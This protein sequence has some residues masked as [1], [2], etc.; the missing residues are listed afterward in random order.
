[1]KYEWKKADKSIYLPKN[2]PEI[3]ELPH[4]KYFMLKGKGNPNDSEFGE[5][6]EALYSVSYGVRMSHKS[7]TAPDGYYE[8]TVF[9]LEGIWDLEEEARGQETLDK[10]KLVYTLMIRQPDFL[11]DELAQIIIEET[12]KKKSNKLIEQIRYDILDEGLNVQMMHIGK[13]DNEAES[14]KL[15]EEFCSENNLVRI[16]K[17]HKEIYISDFR[18][19][20]PDKLKT[21]LRFKVKREI[22]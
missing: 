8:Y 15:M 11:T 14:F 13:Y 4:M 22:K 5:V 1:M 21:V 3:I 16:D 20:D 6:I 10:D 19:T 2:K 9:P 17:T 18:K 7:G 12:N